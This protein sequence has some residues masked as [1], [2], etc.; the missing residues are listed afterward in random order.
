MTTAH[1][2]PSRPSPLAGHPMLHALAENWWLLLL[3][4]VAAIIFGLL[5]FFWPGVTL[6]TLVFLWGAYAIVDGAFSLWAAISG[7]DAIAPRWWLAVVGVA[8]VVAGLL[9]FAWP[10]LTAVILLLFI[11]GWAIVIGALEIWGAIQ[12]RKEIEGEW[13]LILSGVLSIA[14]GI[15]LIAQP[16]VGALAVVWLIA[17]YAILMGCSLIALAF[18]LRKHLHPA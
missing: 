8:G 10:G 17:W 4:G 18:R 15:I 9:A 12:L 3:R 11:A 1:I 13:W 14:F 5:A 7:R 2:Q 6:L 16:G